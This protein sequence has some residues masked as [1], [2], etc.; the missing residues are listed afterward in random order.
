RRDGDRGR[1]DRRRCRGRGRGTDR[2]RAVVVTAAARCGDRAE[3]HQEAH[4]GDPPPHAA[5]CNRDVSRR[6]ATCNDCAM[7]KFGWL[8]RVA[9][10][11]GSN[12]EPIVMY[13]VR[14]ILPTALPYFD[15]VWI[16]VHFYG[17]DKEKTEGFLEGWTTLTWL[18][19]RFPDVMLCHHVLGHGYRNPAL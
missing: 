5:D 2:G 11:A 13:Q 16:A 6:S 15:S 3:A 1:G 14:H 12:F 7:V 19:G 18:A 4:R 17:F 10:H 8:S 9:G